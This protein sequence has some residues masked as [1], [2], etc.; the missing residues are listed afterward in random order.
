MSLL[1]Y[2][3]KNTCMNKI[4][5]ITFVACS[6]VFSF[7]AHAQGGKQ[8]R[9]F[10][11]EAFLAKRSAYITAEVGLTP[12]EAAS[13][14]PLCNE[15]QEKMFE[16]GRD[17]RKLSKDLKQNKNASDADYLKV[18]DECVS[19][20]MKQAQLEKESYEKFKKILSPKKLYKYRRAE[21]KFAREFM[22][23]GDDKKGE[24]R[25]K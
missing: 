10:D 19:V 21:A 14:I 15:L 12:E 4:F 8:H 23:G 20:N 3:C 9:N 7:S 17:C 16:A 13:F 6:V 2:F 22:K 25:K 24:N 11:R 5:F 1:K 18:I